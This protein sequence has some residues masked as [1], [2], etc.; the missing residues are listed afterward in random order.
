MA[1][2]T[3]EP[4]DLRDRVEAALDKLDRNLLLLKGH[5]AAKEAERKRWHLSEAEYLA[6]PPDDRRA[7]SNYL[8]QGASPEERAQVIEVLNTVQKLS[9]RRPDFVKRWVLSLEYILEAE[10][11]DWEQVELFLAGERPTLSDLLLDNVESDAEP[12]ESTTNADAR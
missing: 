6:L 11:V 9:E 12:T 5:F 10:V 1:D 4:P 8:W 2:S 7:Y 3:P